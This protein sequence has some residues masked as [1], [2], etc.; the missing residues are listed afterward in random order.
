VGASILGSVRRLGWFL[1]GATS[2]A[3]ALVAAPRMY[4]RLRA[5]L[6]AGDPWTELEPEEQEW[7]VLREAPPIE[8][9]PEPWVAEAVPYE[10]VMAEPEPEPEA[11]PEYTTVW[12][13]QPV[14]ADAPVEET[15]AEVEVVE[16]EPEPVA[17]VAPEP[18]PVVEA[19]PEQDDD[20]DEITFTPLT[21]A[22]PPDDSTASELRSRIQ[23]S[24]A[25][26]RRKARPADDDAE[27]EASESDEPDDSDE[28]DFSA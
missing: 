2:A 21:S 19:A 18:E 4:E 14:V 16:P 6:G 24:R 3:G 5:A 1:V 28:P 23:A 26:L 12:S 22:P 25:R 15:P 8:T 27:A 7:G 10:P 13:P 20:T 9:E 17:E 11:E